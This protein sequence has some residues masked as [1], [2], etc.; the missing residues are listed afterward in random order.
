[1]YT[2]FSKDF[3]KEKNNIFNIGVL[4]T[5]CKGSSQ[6]I[7]PRN[8]YAPTSKSLLSPLNYDY[9]AFG[10]IHLRSTPIESMPEGDLLSNPQGLNTKDAEMNEKAV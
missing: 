8:P 9:W 6:M 4:H 2:S 10:H 5:D 3:P 7:T 1:M